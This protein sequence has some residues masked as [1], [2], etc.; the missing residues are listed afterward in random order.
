M[1]VSVAGAAAQDWA[2]THHGLTPLPSFRLGKGQAIPTKILNVAV[3]AYLQS[4]H[5]PFSFNFR[6][7]VKLVL[8]SLS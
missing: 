6:K 5:S 4:S 3:P 2:T 7:L 1:N 8:G